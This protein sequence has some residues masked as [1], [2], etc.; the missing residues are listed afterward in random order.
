MRNQSPS[1]VPANQDTYLVL[2]DFGTR[3]G[4][5]WRETDEQAT[6]HDTLI[7]N[8][9]EGQYRHPAC[10][11]AFNTAEGWSRG[12]ATPSNEL[13]QS[14]R[15]SDDARVTYLSLFQREQWAKHSHW[16]QCNVPFFRRLP[17]E[18]HHSRPPWVR[19]TSSRISPHGRCRIQLL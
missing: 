16:A 11:V 14:L 17:V 12:S 6:D 19:P 7:R 13:V 4:R 2:E 8:L 18:I 9:I 10:I 15:Q 1:I 5:A 3:L